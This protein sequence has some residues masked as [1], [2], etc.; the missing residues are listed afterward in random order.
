MCENNEIVEFNN[1]VLVLIFFESYVLFKKRKLEY[2]YLFS[3]NRT[4][5]IRFQENY[6][7]IFFFPNSKSNSTT[8]SKYSRYPQLLPVQSRVP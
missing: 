4:F 1:L 6:K 8:I 5:H 7:K 3:N 2:Y